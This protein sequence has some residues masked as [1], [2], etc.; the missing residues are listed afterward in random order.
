MHTTNYQNTFI[1]PSEDCTAKGRVPDKAGTVAALQFQMLNDAPYALTSDDLLVAVTAMRRD[2][3]KDEHEALHAE[4]FSKGQ[5]C[6][7]ASAL[8]K[9]YGW[10]VHHD[11]QGRVALVA[12]DSPVY[13]PFLDDPTVTKVK[14]MRSTRK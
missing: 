8:V 3:P 5:P 9:T 2:I 6:L 12:P 10:A 7:R 1:E 14:G 13:Q 4:L 11:G